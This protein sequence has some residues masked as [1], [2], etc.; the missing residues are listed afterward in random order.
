LGYSHHSA[1]NGTYGRL[2]KKLGEALQWRPDSELGVAVLTT[3]TKPD[4]Y[5]RWHMRPELAT[6]LERLGLANPSTMALPEESE[7][8]SSYAEGASKRITVNAYER[9]P[10]ARAKCIEVHGYACGVCGITMSEVYGELGKQYIHVHHLQQLSDVIAGHEVNPITDLRPVCPNCHAMIHRRSPPYT[11]EE[12]KT[13]ID[14]Y[15]NVN[16]VLHPDGESV[17]FHP[18]R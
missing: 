7:D 14:R 12:L 3:F 13:Q 4:A 18:R 17:A 1:A 6:A 10:A 11:I 2:G 16:N 9:N 15:R 5:W 8:A